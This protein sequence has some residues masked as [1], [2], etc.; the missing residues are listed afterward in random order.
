MKI[1]G[2]FKLKYT[3]KCVVT[4]DLQTLI[5]KINGWHV[6]DITLIVAQQHIK[7]G[8]NEIGVGDAKVPRFVNT[9]ES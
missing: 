2:N 3:I 1:K 5:V 8:G 4:R 9:P 7:V 6:Y